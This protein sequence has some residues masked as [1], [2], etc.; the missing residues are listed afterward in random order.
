MGSGATGLGGG[1]GVGA[2]RVSAGF[3]RAGRGARWRAFSLLPFFLLVLPRS[4]AS[5]RPRNSGDPA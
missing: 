3:A 4:A 2:M 1:C 5:W